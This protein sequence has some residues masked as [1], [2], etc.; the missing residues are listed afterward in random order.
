[1]NRHAFIC[2]TLLGLCACMGTS[3]GN[4]ANASKDAG[5]AAD[6]S[7][8]GTVNEGGFCDA[9]KA[10]LAALDTSTSLGFTAADVLALARGQHDASLQWLS[11]APETYGP[12]SGV[13]QLHI[14]VTAPAPKPRL[15]HLTLKQASGATPAIEIG[16]PGCFDRIELDVLVHVT[17]DGG[18]LDESFDATLSAQTSRLAQLHGSVLAAAVGGAFKLSGNSNKQAFV[19]DALTF[20]MSFTHFGSGGQL[21]ASLSSSATQPDAGAGTSTGGVS[22]QVNLAR[23]PAGADCNFQGLGVSAA[24]SVDKLSVQAGR[25]LVAAA[26]ALTLKWQAGASTAL[27]LGFTPTGDTACVA[28]LDDP[29]GAIPVTLSAPGTLHVTTADGRIDATWPV[30]LAVVADAQGALDH[31]AITRDSNTDPF[32]DANAFEQ[33][34]GIHGVDLAGYDKASVELMLTFAATGTTSG[35][36]TVN[37]AVVPACATDKPLPVDAGTAGGSSSPGCAGYMLTPLEQATIASP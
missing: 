25:D 19:L 16:T 1:M 28:G 24:S 14:T 21:L 34:Y 29:S 7:F 2:V 32:V 22:A 9:Q 23:W 30:M 31:V 8:E 6:G 10:P 17:T 12:E 26:H 35:A 20:E 18:A 27:T 3:T 37:G 4:P 13:G 11:A 33:S 15:V 5:G 36:L